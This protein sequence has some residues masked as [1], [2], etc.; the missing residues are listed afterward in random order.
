[1]GGTVFSISKAGAFGVLRSITATVDR[2]AGISQGLAIPGDGWAYSATMAQVDGCAGA[3]FRIDSAGLFQRLHCFPLFSVT[4]QTYPGGF[5]VHSPLVQGPDGALYG[6]AA[7][8]GLANA[9]VIFRISPSGAFSVEHHFSGGADG[10]L[11]WG[12]LTLGPDGF[13]YGTTAWGG[14]TGNGTVFRY[15]PNVGVMK[16]HDFG[17]SDGSAPL[18]PLLRVG[19][20]LFGTT[21][22]GGQ[23]ARGIVFRLTF[24]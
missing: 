22:S 23:A 7:G 3:I 10:S 13:L 18:G 1:M 2:A 8:G 19:N 16:I 20:S 21:S 5:G 4:L 15:A 14:G 9:G 6:T 11:P 17:F 24:D 12:G